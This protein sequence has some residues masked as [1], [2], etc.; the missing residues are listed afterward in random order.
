[1]DRVGAELS[2]RYRENAGHGPNVI[3]L[4]DEI[5]AP[6]RA[7]LLV[8]MS[9]VAFLL[10]IACTNVATLLLARSAGRRRELAVRSAIGAG[11]ARLLRQSLTESLLIAVI[12]GALGLI[13]ASWTNRLLLA[14][15]PAVLRGVGLERAR[16][17]LPVLMFTAL[18][19]LLTTVVAGAL[20][21]WQ[22][23][24]TPPGDPLREAGRSP[25]TLRRTVRV[26]L[27]GAQVALTLLLLIGAGLMVRSFVRVLSQP[28]GLDTAN[29]LVI[30][31]TF[32]RSR[33]PD[34][35][36]VRRVRRQ[37]DERFSGMPG[38]IAAGASN[39]LPLSGADSRQGVTVDGYQR[40][41]D[42]SPVRAHIR[43]VT[44]GYF[45]AA[46]IAVRNGRS[47]TSLDTDRA[48]LVV[49]INETMARRYWPG[50]SPL[51]KRVRLNG[52]GEP[53]WREVV[54]VIGDVRH[55]GLDREVN[56]ELYI[57]HDQLPTAGLAYVLHAASD[58]LSLVAAAASHVSAVDA[59]L[60]LGSVR[61]FDAVAASST[62]SRRWSALLLGLFAALGLVLA[63][64]GIYGVMTHLVSL[65][66]GEIG[67]RLTL[68]ARPSA[69]LGH[70]LGEAMLNTAVGLVVGLAAGAAATRAL[71]SLLYE[72]APLDPLTFAAAALTV[73]LVAGLAA[74]APAARAMRVDP[75][76]TLRGC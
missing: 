23:A 22:V 39:N 61:T 38:V 42:E 20:P 47:F 62:A 21:A 54:G 2:S 65:Q 26:L 43:I 76:Q 9:G 15:T 32:P 3:P 51:G 4:R 27:I 69:V 55:W 67:I 16:L 29:R 7:G 11:R 73:L 5:V 66:T 63:A 41:A 72:I 35:D 44:A 68:G 12:G 14:E 19:C 34:G 56:P 8:V 74:A 40:Q 58:P 24:R 70:V 37:L 60:P 59:D 28:A 10:L 64:A 1:M 13:V 31:L 57:P 46:G 50:Q 30:N 18:I 45:T 6:A 52:E 36:A 25:L 17:D 75:V 49:V 53:P 71:Q 48:P 33:Y